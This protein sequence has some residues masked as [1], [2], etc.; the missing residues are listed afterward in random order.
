MA[1]A[2]KKYVSQ[3]PNT[4][5]GATKGSSGRSTPKKNTSVKMK[6]KGK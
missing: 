2:G 1:K 5:K 3:R 6:K 4:S